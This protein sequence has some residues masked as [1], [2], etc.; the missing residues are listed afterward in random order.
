M[1]FTAGKMTAIR[2]RN[3]KNDLG[4]FMIFAGNYWLVMQEKPINNLP[5]DEDKKGNTIAK[6]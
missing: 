3:S 5:P 6:R 4:Q 2:L 1:L